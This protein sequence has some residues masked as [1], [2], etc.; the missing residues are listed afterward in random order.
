MCV[1]AVLVRLVLL[2]ASGLQPFLARC[3]PAQTWSSPCQEA[4]EPGGDAGEDSGGGNSGTRLDR[5]SAAPCSLR[6]KR[7]LEP[8]PAS[9]PEDGGAQQ[10]LALCSRL[11]EAGQSAESRASPPSRFQ[12]FRMTPA[13]RGDTFH[14]HTG[15]GMNSPGGAKSP[16]PR[17]GMG[18]GFLQWL[19]SLRGAVF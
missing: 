8:Q 9:M 7:A 15:P 10:Q 12:A 1:T 4:A 19:Q 5:G 17:H 16:R 11:G 2:L 3:G 14:R 18:A 13:Y 6:P